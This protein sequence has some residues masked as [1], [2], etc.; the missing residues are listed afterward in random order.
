[1]PWKPSTLRCRMDISPGDTI[2]IEGE[3]GE[4]RVAM[5][6]PDQW[7][8]VQDVSEAMSMV[9]ESLVTKIDKE[10]VSN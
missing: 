7:L 5:P 8:L 1:M 2:T 10:K 4:F 6:L 9:H 3:E